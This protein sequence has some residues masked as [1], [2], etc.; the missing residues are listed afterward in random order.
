MDERRPDYVFSDFKTR[1]FGIAQ[2]QIKK[3][4]RMER[5]ILVMAIAMYWAVS[6][7]TADEKMTALSGEKRGS[8]NHKDLS[9]LSSN[10]VYASFVDA[11]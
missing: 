5:L 9:A 7:G 10:K 11:S 1:G 3:P 4:E 6:T 2:S 8:E